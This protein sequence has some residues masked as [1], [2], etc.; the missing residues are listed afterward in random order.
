MMRQRLGLAACFAMLMVVGN[1]IAA[2]KSANAEEKT[3]ADQTT[4]MLKGD[5]VP[6]HPHDI[7]FDHLPRVPSQHV[8]VSDVRKEKGV[9]QHNYLAFHE[10][11]FWIMWSNGPGIEDQA[12]Q[13][14]S[15]ATSPDGLTW[16]EPKFLSPVPPHSGKDS[17]V[18]GTRSPDGF[19]WIARGFWQRDGELYAL[20]SLDQ[21]AGFFGPALELHA[22]R[23]DNQAQAWGDSQIIQDNAINNFPP[24]K[25]PS[26][27]WM[28][29]RR[30]HDYKKSG[31]QF[32]VG[33]VEAIDQWDSVPVFKSDA[34]LAAEEPYWWVLPDN[35]RMVALFRDN[36]KSGYL[37][38]SF[39]EDQGKS[40][41]PPHRTDFPDARSKFSGVRLEDGRYVLVSNPHPKRRDPLAISISDDGV[42][43]TKMGYLIGGRHVDYPHVIQHGS[44][45]LVAFAGGKQTVEVLKIKLEDL[46][47]L[48]MP[49]Q[50]LVKP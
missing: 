41:S 37:Y 12:G 36:H 38:R 43:F 7:D 2:T 5:W 23:W 29:S 45:L 15:Y 24:K 42:V 19:R 9:H 18:Y 16:S 47:K 50:P 4:V 40:W 34:E 6:A 30:M 13:R 21:S 20:A 26:G 44:D 48:T 25:I 10:G 28:I 17:K 1:G 31:V 32:L 22:F 49:N 33:G 14:V 39:S 8:V 46:N 35:Q 11:Q 3:P 27:Q